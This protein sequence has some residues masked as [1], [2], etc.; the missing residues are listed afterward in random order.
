MIS[1]TTIAFLAG[2]FCGAILAAIVFAIFF[3][4]KC[5]RCGA[6]IERYLRVKDNG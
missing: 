3:T 6:K 2:I 4:L 1:G 5:Q